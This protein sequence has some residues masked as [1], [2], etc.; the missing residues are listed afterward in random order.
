MECVKVSCNKNLGTKVNVRQNLQKLVTFRKSATEFRRAVNKALVRFV[1]C[2]WIER[3]ISSRF[4]K[5]GGYEL[6]INCNT[7][8]TKIL[9]PDS[10]QIGTTSMAAMPEYRHAT[11]SDCRV[12]C[13]ANQTMARCLPV[14]C[15]LKCIVSV[16]CHYI[17]PLY[18][19]TVIYFLFRDNRIILFMPPFVACAHCE[20]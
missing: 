13:G 9:D 19:C 3:T 16:P 7:L 4:L 10:W 17:L 20:I 1:T 5:C 2:L 11:L 15:V 6:I 12:T 8:K 18:S 14:W